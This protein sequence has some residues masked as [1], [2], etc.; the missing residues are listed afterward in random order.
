MDLREALSNASQILD[1]E[2]V[3][4]TVSYEYVFDSQARYDTAGMIAMQG[5]AALAGTV[6]ISTLRSQRPRE[7]QTLI[8]YRFKSTNYNLLCALLS[9][10]NENDRIAFTANVAARLA[11]APGCAK[12]S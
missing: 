5:L 2:R 1:E 7:I 6:N 10:L 9:R 12:K 8:S 11:S 3:A 4:P